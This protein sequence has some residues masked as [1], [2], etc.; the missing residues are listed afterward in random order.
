MTGISKKIVSVNRKI[1]PFI[2]SISEKEPLGSEKFWRR[3][4]DLQ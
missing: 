3:Q 4:V 1:K 2:N